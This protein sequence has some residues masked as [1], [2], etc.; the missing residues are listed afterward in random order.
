MASTEFEQKII[1]EE[2]DEAPRTRGIVLNSLSVTNTS[3]AVAGKDFPTEDEIKYLIKYNNAAQERCVTVSD[4]KLRVTLMPPKY[5][6]PFRV[7]AIEENN[8]ISLS[9]LG[10]DYNG[11]LT[12]YLPETLIENIEEYM[13]HYRTI[14]DYIECRS[15]KIYN[16]GFAINLF[17]SKT[18]D[19]PTVLN[20][21]VIK[22]KEYMSVG[23]HNMGEDIF[24]GDLEKEI[25]MIDGVVSIIDFAVYSIY[26]GTY[27]TDRCPY[28]EEGA[29][30]ICVIE[31]DTTFKVDDNAKSFRIDLNSID[32]VLYSDYDSMFEIRYP[33]SD[34]QL[35]AKLI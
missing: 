6:A 21:V 20:N 34:I 11:R 12:K 30:N 31:N 26:D 16:I 22:I 2:A 19:V 13:S 18:Y 5:G 4:Y 9:M 33:D 24:L 25:T 15:G 8:K 23:N 28:S 27:S 29:N 1:G 17:I 14:S 10:L 7:A 3:P 35:K 32:Y